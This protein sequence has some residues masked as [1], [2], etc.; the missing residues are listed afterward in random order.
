[1]PELVSPKRE[2]CKLRRLA[3]VWSFPGWTSSDASHETAIVLYHTTVNTSQL[4][5]CVRAARN[6]IVS[7]CGLRAIGKKY[8]EVPGPGEQLPAAVTTSLHQVGSS[9]AI[10]MQAQLTVAEAGK[11]L[12]IG[13]MYALGY[14][15]LN[16]RHIPS[17]GRVNTMVL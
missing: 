9:F 5:F 15:S 17:R 4:R 7:V 8:R 1:M 16:M 10:S 14:P 11:S 12:A 6:K 13:R 3:N 2:N